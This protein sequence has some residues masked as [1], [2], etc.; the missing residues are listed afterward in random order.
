M[1]REKTKN[2]NEIIYWTLSADV[3]L[4]GLEIKVMRVWFLKCLFL[5]VEMLVTWWSNSQV[6]RGHLNSHRR[7]ISGGVMKVNGALGKMS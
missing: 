2:D 4:R 1:S 5:H 6:I 3:Q 7:Q